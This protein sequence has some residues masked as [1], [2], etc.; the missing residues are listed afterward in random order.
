MMKKNV[1]I[2]K[3][4]RTYCEDIES[5]LERFG[6]DKMVFDTDRDYRNSVCMSLLQIGELTGHLSEDFRER[7][8]EAIYWPAIKGMRNLFAHNYGAVDIDR[9]WETAISDIPVLHLFCDKTIHRLHLEEQEQ[10]EMQENGNSKKEMKR[11]GES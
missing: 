7:T 9:V 10:S 6:K 3:H 2:L 8:R 5:A 11:Y 1:D 4:I